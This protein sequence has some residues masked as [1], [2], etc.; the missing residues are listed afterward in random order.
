MNERARLRVG[1]V[2]VGHLGKEHA[3]VMA[4]LPGAELVGVYDTRLDVGRKVA[5]ELGTRALDSLDQL[6]SCVEAVSVAVPTTAHFEVASACIARGIHVMVE[7]PL[8]ATIEEARALVDASRTHSV[9]VQTGH[10]E[11]FNPIVRAALSVVKEPRFIESHRLSSFVGRSTDVDVVLDLMIHDI[12][13]A[14]ATVQSEIRSVEA[15]G[16]PILSPNVDIA[17]ARLLFAN[18]AVANLTASRVSKERV[19][20]IRFFARDSYVSVDCLAGKAE[21][22]KKGFEAK[23]A[24]EELPWEESQIAPGIVRR[25]IVVS[26]QEPLRLEL[27]HFVKCVLHGERPA[28]DGVAGLK[29]MEAALKVSE[30]IAEGIE[31]YRLPSER[32]E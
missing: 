5:N 3:R 6:L 8:A 20:K 9:I 27:E 31:R 26:G 24:G 12:D 25:T 23:R 10:I 11:R 16:V 18:G 17:N 19:R 32:Q 2:G 28:V 21:L 1:V 7:K 29:A 15:T 14:L 30:K 22:Y 13:L 4:S